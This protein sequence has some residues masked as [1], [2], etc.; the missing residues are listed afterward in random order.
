M[1]KMKMRLAVFAVIVGIFEGAGVVRGEVFSCEGGEYGNSDTGY[2]EPCP[3]G[4]YQ[5]QQAHADACKNC[6]SGSTSQLGSMSCVSLPDCDCDCDCSDIGP[7]G[8]GL[9][10]GLSGV[11]VVILFF[12]YTKRKKIFYSESLRSVYQNSAHL[13]F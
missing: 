2:C 5:D 9:V 12:L 6:P 13:N 11:L 1:T 10:L 8:L 4:T 7:L 3:P